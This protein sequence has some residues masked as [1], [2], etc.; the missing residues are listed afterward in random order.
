S[1]GYPEAWYLPAANNI[2]RGYATEGSWYAYFR[3]KAAVRLPSPW[4]PG[5]ATFDYSNNQPAATLW[6]HD[7]TLGI[8]RANVRAVLAAFYLLRGDAGDTALR[9]LLP[10]PAPSVGDSPSA[11]YYEI[12]I[13]IQ[14]RSFNAD[15]SLFFPSDRAFFEGVSPA[16][17]QIPFIPDSACNG[18]P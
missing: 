1:D 10:G 6:A 17:L 7:H 5:T 15:G 11:N 8:T 14:D 4:A 3:N 18:R 12:P 16:E 9:G 2:P 13:A